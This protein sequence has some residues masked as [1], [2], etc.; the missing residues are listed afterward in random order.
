MKVFVL[1]GYEYDVEKW[2]DK[3]DRGE[4]PDRTPYGYH[5][6]SDD[7]FVLTFS[8]SI[9]EGRSTRLFRIALRK[10]FGFD[11]VH[12][13]RNRREMTQCDAVWTH[14]EREYLA[15]AL[16]MLMLRSR[17][18][19]LIA[20]S[21]WLFDQWKDLSLFK[22]VLYSWL[23][24]KRVDVLTFLSNQNLRISRHIFPGIRHCMIPFGISLE[25]F[26][27]VDVGKRE[28][29][30]EHTVRVLAVGN[31]RHRD[32]QTLV[33]ALGEQDGVEVRI[34]TSTIDSS[35]LPGNVIVLQATHGDVVQNYEW[36]DIAVIPLV[37]NFHASGITALLEAVASALP[38][39]CTDVGGL[40][41]YFGEEEVLFVP[42]RDPASIREAVAFLRNNPEKAITLVEN[43]QKRLLE[44][45]YTSHDYANRYRSLTWQI[46]RGE[47]AQG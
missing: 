12:T 32:W 9:P 3:Y 40:R 22:K 2:S 21:V 46:L 14:T 33:Q 6:A 24:S 34:L 1:L 13:W 44:S 47:S 17:A 23:I 43:S 38:V 29:F 25:S 42:E 28:F 19:R 35:Q 31:D 45:G 16:V 20:Q 11:L 27:I 4:V 30:R 18:P 41:D 8:K 7:N 10:L 26:P 37:N 36:A 15:A 5:K 39:I